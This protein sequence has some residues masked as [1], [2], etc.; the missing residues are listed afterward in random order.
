MHLVKLA[1]FFAVSVSSVPSILHAAGPRVVTGPSKL[2]YGYRMVLS[3]DAKYVAIAETQGASGVWE[4]KTRKITIDLGFGYSE[5]AFSADA[6]RLAVIKYLT[7]SIWDVE[8]SKK[9]R[10][11]RVKNAEFSRLVFSVDGKTVFA[12]G[13]RTLAMFDVRT[14][15]RT[16][17]KEDTSPRR[18]PTKKSSFSNMDCAF[19]TTT[20]PA[21]FKGATEIAVSKDG[22]WV[23]F[24][25][26][27]P[28]ALF[29][30]DLKS[31][32]KATT[33]ITKRIGR[34]EVSF[35]DAGKTVAFFDDDGHFKL[36]SVE[37]KAF[38]KSAKKGP[39]VA[40]GSLPISPKADKVATGV[41]QQQI[42]VLAF[43]SG[44]VL[45]EIDI[46]KGLKPKYIQF[47]PDGKFIV[48][49]LTNNSVAFFK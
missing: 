48:A 45:K 36:W 11:I 8:R 7:L 16:T 38:V 21:K 39:I 15:R 31:K 18:V 43:P 17:L 9:I 10:D 37:K 6:K 3:P 14:G 22:R 34:P 20:R 32:T 5:A 4:V 23:A 33:V 19:T 47:S 41:F 25:G 1:A 28:S 49:L 42:T 13:R 35:L 26:A 24:S 27:Y 40:S 29:L 12:G 44:R 46:P 30:M 2:N